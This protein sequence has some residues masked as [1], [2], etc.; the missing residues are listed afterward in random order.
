MWELEYKESW[1]WKNWCFRTVVLEKTLESPLDCKEI[2]P[3]H[4]KKTSPE[5]SLK[6]L[7][8]KLK[9]QYFGYQMWRA[10]S[11][12][13]TL[14]PGNIK[15][16]R[17]RGPQRMKWLVGITDQ[18]TWVWTSSGSWWTG[19]PDVLQTMGSQTVGYDWKTKWNLCDHFCCWVF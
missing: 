4:P 12:E 19:K 18:W 7:I 11:L 2:Q 9:L 3:V 10:D 5:Y 15:G 13:K 1:V 6:G 16:G 17:R 14:M 8:L